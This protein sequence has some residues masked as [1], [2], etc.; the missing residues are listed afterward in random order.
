MYDDGKLGFVMRVLW[1]QSLEWQTYV[2]GALWC[3][4]QKKRNWNWYSSC[5]SSG[6]VT[7]MWGSQTCPLNQYFCFFCSFHVLV[8]RTDSLKGRRG[9]LPSKPKTVAEAS[10]TTPH[11]N[12]IASLVRA[13]LDSNPTIGKLDYSKVKINLW[14]LHSQTFLILI[15]LVSEN[16]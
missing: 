2:T 14:E 9:R 11:V 8:V 16:V 10:S 12:I 4:L 7:A 13:H 15:Q 3:Q 1:N 6:A 5:F